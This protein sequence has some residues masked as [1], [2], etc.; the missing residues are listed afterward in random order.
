MQRTMSVFSHN[1]TLSSSV[2]LFLTIDDHWANN[3]TVRWIGWAHTPGGS[4]SPTPASTHLF[5]VS[6]TIILVKCYAYNALPRLLFAIICC[7][8]LFWY[9]FTRRT[10]A[11][12]SIF[13]T[14]LSAWIQLFRELEDGIFEDDGSSPLWM[15]IWVFVA[16][17]IH[18]IGLWRL[19]RIEI[20]WRNRTSWV[21]TVH[22]SSPTHPERTS[23]RLD[24]RV[25][26]TVKFMVCPLPYLSDVT[27]LMTFFSI[28]IWR[29]RRTLPLRRTREHISDRE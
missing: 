9:F 18:V 25:S 20:S 7:V 29:A 13:A 22:L 23:E 21:P 24:G 8:A 12:I 16:G 10:T 5:R 19:A 15:A 28:D 26:S 3:H 14:A 6:L 17:A 2:S 11:G 1:T 27:S 4:A